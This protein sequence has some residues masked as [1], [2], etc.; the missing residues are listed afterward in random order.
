MQRNISSQYYYRML[1]TQKKELVESEMKELTASYQNDK[2]EFIKNPVVA[3]FLG[4]SQNT[5]FTESDLEKSILS[6]LQKFLMELGK[7]YA[8][9][10][11]QQHIHTEKQDY[12]IDLVFYNYILKCF[13]LIDLKTEKITHQDVGQMDMYIRTSVMARRLADGHVQYGWSGNGGYFRVV[14]LRLL[15]WYK[16]PEDVEY[17]FRLGQTSFIGKKGSEKGGFGWMETHSLTGEPC[18]LDQTERMIFS[19]M[20]FADYGYFYDTDQKWYYIIPGPFRIKMPLELVYN[21]LDE[22]D[23]EF[24]FLEEIQDKVLT[25]I[26]TEY[27][28]NHPK[29]AEVLK[30]EG[31]TPEEIMKTIREKESG[32]LN[33]YRFFEKY[34]NVFTYFDDWILVKADEEYSEITEII[35]KEKGVAH[36]ETN[37]W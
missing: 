1:G 22:D 33:M 20:A 7:G 23:F 4:F 35:V 34:R 17:L 31:Y 37:L 32:L 3:E 6:N 36:I 13:V 10:A 16:A 14:G 29:F 12:Y 28:E 18:W 9:V 26:L 24:D 30:K 15:V 21:N 2:L 27:I 19:K 11:R 8:F 25:Y 5:D